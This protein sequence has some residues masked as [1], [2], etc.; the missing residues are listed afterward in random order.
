MVAGAGATGYLIGTGASS[1]VNDVRQ[2]VAA[3][4]AVAT[5]SSERTGERRGRRKG[6]ASGT[7]AG[8]RDGEQAGARRGASAAQHELASQEKDRADA[9]EAQQ[10]QAEEAEKAQRAKNCDEPLFVEGYCPTDEEVEQEGK[11]ESLCGGGDYERAKAEGIPCFPP[12][13][14]RNP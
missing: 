11:A 1:D 4:K 2:E 12:G 6:F 5:R 3:A 7:A 13:D 10:Q 8:R 9:A 14:P